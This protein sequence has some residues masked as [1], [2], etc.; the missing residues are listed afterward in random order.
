MKTLRNCLFCLLLTFWPIVVFSA[1]TVGLDPNLKTD[2]QQAIYRANQ[3]IA[4]YENALESGNRTR[5]RCAALELQ[6]D[7][8][9]IRQVN[10]LKSDAFKT[11]LNTDIQ[12][13]Q[14]KTKAIIKRELAKIHKVPES[15]V[16]FFEATNPSDEIKVG[17]DWDV[18]AQVNGKDVD[19][20]I[21]KKVAHEAFYE[22]AKG[23]KAPSSAVAE[24]FAESQSVE[25]TNRSHAEAY[26][27]G[28]RNTVYNKST[29][30]YEV[31]TEGGEIIVGDKRKPLRDPEQLTKVMEHKSHLGKNN[32]ANMRQAGETYI[33][34][35]NLKGESAEQI[36]R[37]A[38]ADAQAWEMEQARQYTKQ[39]K[40][41]VIP[42][43]AARSGKVHSKVWQGTEILDQV[44]QGK[45]SMTEGRAQ[46]KE[47]GETPESII[48]KGSSQIEAAQKIKDSPSKIIKRKKAGTAPKD[49][50]VDN[51]KDNLELKRLQ[52]KK[53]PP[54]SLL[55]GGKSS[56][57]GD[58]PPP[59]YQPKATLEEVRAKTEAR[60]QSEKL[61]SGKS[62]NR[63]KSLLDG[64]KASVNNPE[65]QISKGSEPTQAKAKEKINPTKM[66]TGK[67]QLSGK[68]ATPALD[69]MAA[70][71]KKPA[72]LLDGG[73][74]SSSLLPEPPA[75]AAQIDQTVGGK[76][77][78]TIGVDEVPGSAGGFRK[79]VTKSGDAALGAVAVAA[80][81]AEGEQ[82]GETYGE[83]L[84]AKKKADLYRKQALKARAEGSFTVADKYDKRAE[85]YE[86]EA[87]QKMTKG[88]KNEAALVGSLA[89]A[90]S[91]TGGA[92][93]G[94]YGAYKT[95]E[96]SY[97]AGKSLSERMLQEEYAREIDQAQKEGRKPDEAVAQARALARIGGEASG[98][99]WAMEQ[100]IRD[101][102]AEKAATSIDKPLQEKR[103]AAITKL[104]IGLDDIAELERLLRNLDTNKLQSS[105]WVYAERQRLIQQY[106]N[107]R[108][109]LQKLDQRLGPDAGRGNGA[110]TAI[111]T[112]VQLLPEK[113]MPEPLSVV[114]GK[115]DASP[116]VQEKSAI[117][118][119]EPIK[120][121]ASP[122]PPPAV[123]IQKK[124]NREKPSGKSVKPQA[125]SPSRYSSAKDTSPEKKSPFSTLK[126]AKNQPT[127]G[128]SLPD[129]VGMNLKDAVDVL[130]AVGL[131]ALPEVG[132]SALKPEDVGKVEAAFPAQDGEVHA[133]DQIVV[134]VY[135]GN[136]AGGNV[137]NTIG[138]QLAE[139][140]EA[141]K[142]AGFN[143]VLELGDETDDP[144]KDGT[145]ADQA[146]QPGM[147]IETGKDVRLYIYSLVVD[148]RCV[149]NLKGLQLKTAQEKLK[150]NDLFITPYLEKAAQNKSD[151]GMVY[152]Q[153]PEPGLDVMNGIAISVWVYGEYEAPV[154]KVEKVRKKTPR[155]IVD[156][157]IPYID[158]PKTLFT[159]RF[160][161]G[162][163]RLGAGREKSN[164]MGGR[165]FL[166]K[167]VRGIY[168]SYDPPWDKASH[169]TQFLR[170]SINWT[171]S[172]DIRKEFLNPQNSFCLES[173]S[174]I[175]VIR[176]GSHEFTISFSGYKRAVK[177][178]IWGHMRPKFLN[179]NTLAEAKHLINQI[180][181]Q[182]EPYAARC[183]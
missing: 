124:E 149:P 64:G 180:Y 107:K 86:K 19:L 125:S 58:A 23:S 113:Q 46:L 120:N 88:L 33:K 59:E 141:I 54:K 34:E 72:S 77:L 95:G 63:P 103:E 122:A 112:V 134:Q 27:G 173:D 13:I 143:P 175:K 6:K 104:D 163:V 61:R 28:G 37:M 24:H 162:S 111:R 93:L 84:L 98:A 127:A 43:V 12:S 150:A 136:V 145:I 36:R 82:A 118:K 44:A 50:L 171:E 164:F 130:K 22:A 116:A 56:F 109:E 146:P 110:A 132:K 90:G 174:G 65:S 53:Q 135:A 81:A 79:G 42:R 147:E 67:K 100:L 30:K 85:E 18:T 94:V 108:R 8:L 60:L 74:T 70:T 117:T 7:P 9:A 161:R 40:R 140:A 182:I 89:V 39:F 152:K 128:I 76:I 29:G 115:R 11:R 92:A 17:Q 47:M 172:R 153:Y 170:I 52:A 48:A 114:R 131:F 55:D 137:P 78:K 97:G 176:D 45:I 179:T 15:A 91:A 159:Y 87:S 106:N 4:N 49:V 31:M 75:K 3:R 139:A 144:K 142:L 83:G 1:P 20:K 57:Q 129:V 35:N 99:R 5:I 121:T 69:K 51:V 62:I 166:T 156:V 2:F 68:L 167:G 183:R 73:K 26:G 101:R 10:N 158:I 151:V 160:E 168:I 165:L 126:T 32:A 155:Q 21:A 105:A 96:A 181:S 133:G 154:Q 16:T 102:K 169:T 66:K 119:P 138:M 41:Q 38:E 80:T 25:V 178:K 177:I 14:I 123:T 157:G 71:G 148:T